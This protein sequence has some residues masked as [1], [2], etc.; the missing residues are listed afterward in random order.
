MPESADLTRGF[1]PHSEGRCV[2]SVQP[3]D[4]TVTW[5]PIP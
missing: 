3:A 1:D 2:W 4:T 5:T